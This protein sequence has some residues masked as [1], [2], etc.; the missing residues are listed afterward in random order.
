MNISWLAEIN[1]T[2]AEIKEILKDEPDLLTLHQILRRKSGDEAFF[3]ILAEFCKTKII[4]NQRP[5]DRLKKKF[6]QDHNSIPAYVLARKLEIHERTVQ[7]WLRELKTV[8][9]VSD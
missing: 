5:I 9:C 7:N 8:E 6:V 2:D 3:N 4:F 1:L